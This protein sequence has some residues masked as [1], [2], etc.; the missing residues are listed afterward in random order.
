MIQEN[1]FNQAF[2]VEKDVLLIE[3]A[4]KGNR[5]S[6]NEL[7]ERHNNF[8][9]NIAIKM[10][11]N[12]EDAKDITQDILIKVVTNLARFDAKKAQFRTW[13]YHIAFNSILNYKKSNTEKNIVSFAQFFDFVEQVPDDQ[14]IESDEKEIDNLSNETMIKC[15]SG[16][17]MCIP[18]EDRLLYILGDLFKVDHN[19]G[20]VL[21]NISKENFRKKL[22]R[23]RKDL[24]QWMNNKCGLVNKENPCRCRKKTKGFIERGIVDPKNL[25]WDKD[26]TQRINA[27]STDN[28]QETLRSSDAI[29]ARL[30]QNHPFKESTATKEVIE[31]ILTDK[32]LSEILNL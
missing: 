8:I 23:T 28:L 20:A 15:M 9:Y 4:L 2:D 26:F 13:L 12:V 6:L 7:L 18:R 16:M 31:D 14:I 5:K 1:P 29:Y 24:R 10:L 19:L 25:I 17:L 21:F 32:N 27:Y 30:Y 22:S 11:G 3:L